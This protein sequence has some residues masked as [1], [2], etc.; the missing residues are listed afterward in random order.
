MCT[1]KDCGLTSCL[2]SCHRSHAV[3]TGMMDVPK[4][5]EQKVEELCDHYDNVLFDMTDEEIDGEYVGK[6][7]I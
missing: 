2:C 1:C 4:S 7:G 6:V 3:M 5:R